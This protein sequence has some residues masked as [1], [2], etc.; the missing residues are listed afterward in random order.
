MAGLCSGQSAVAK[1]GEPSTRT[2]ARR[3]ECSAPLQVSLQASPENDFNGRYF[4]PLCSLTSDILYNPR[5]PCA[6]IKTGVDLGKRAYHRLL[7]SGRHI[8]EMDE[9]RS[10]IAELSRFASAVGGSCRF[11]PGSEERRAAA[12]RVQVAHGEG[13]RRQRSSP[14]RRS[15][16]RLSRNL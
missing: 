13:A 8:N 1:G 11:V 12:N 9:A 7:I 4:L 5:K 3:D 6:I 2:L 10:S 15:C 16:R 14:F